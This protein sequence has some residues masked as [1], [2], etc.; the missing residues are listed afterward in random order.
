MIELSSAESSYC[1]FGSR[2]RFDEDDGE[3]R[4]VGGGYWQSL[5]RSVSPSLFLLASLPSILPPPIISKS[6]FLWRWMNPTTKACTFVF[7]TRSPLSSLAG[8]CRTFPPSN[9]TAKPIPLRKYGKY[10]SNAGARAAIGD[11]K[12][13]HFRF[14]SFVGC[15]FLYF[16]ENQTESHFLI[17]FLAVV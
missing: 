15:L 5:R 9:Q 10:K 13:Y 17:F 7:F 8:F 16:R 14:F 3:R 2:S 1:E 4:V 6:G 11:Y 12:F